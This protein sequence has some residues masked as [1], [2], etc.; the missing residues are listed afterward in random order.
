MS[1]GWWEASQTSVSV[2]TKGG[3]WVHLTLPLGQEGLQEA[4]QEIWVGAGCRRLCVEAGVP[5]GEMSSAAS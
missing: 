1:D 5:A 3:G 2:G 4:H